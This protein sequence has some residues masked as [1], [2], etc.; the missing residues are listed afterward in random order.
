MTTPRRRT[1]M[2]QLIT[3]G[4]CFAAADAFAQSTAAL[5]ESN[6]QAAAMGYKRDTTKVDAAKHPKRNNTQS[7]AKCQLYQGRAG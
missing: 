4:S 3:A 6:P 2:V 5:D 1:S 7:C